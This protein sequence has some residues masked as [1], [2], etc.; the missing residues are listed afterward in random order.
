MG[1]NWD[2]IAKKAGETTDEQFK[3]Q[4][5]SLTRLNDSEIESLIND[6]GISKKD[7]ANVIK[8]IK[9]ATKSNTAKAQAIQ[10]ISKGV[11]ALISIVGR[12]I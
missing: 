6:T 5:S 11:D 2:E 9:D 12:L 8:E 1:I 10:K 4:I 3:N 7:L